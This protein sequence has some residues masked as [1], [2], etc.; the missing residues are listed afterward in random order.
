MALESCN[1]TEALLLS[2]QGDA[3]FR[4]ECASIIPV[5]FNTLS[6]AMKLF[7][8]YAG[9]IRNMIL[10]GKSDAAKVLSAEIASAVAKLYLSPDMGSSEICNG[11]LKGVL[12]DIRNVCVKAE[13]EAFKQ[14]RLRDTYYVDENGKLIVRC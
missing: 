11:I 4:D 12:D 3:A 10:A 14:D 13:A 9:G 6:A 8:D 5:E 7:R 2:L 1:V